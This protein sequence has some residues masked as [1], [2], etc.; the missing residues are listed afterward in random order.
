MIFFSLF[1]NKFKFFIDEL[2]YM[3]FKP[4]LND[5]PFSHEIVL[6][7]NLKYFR[8]EFKK[9]GIRQFWGFDKINKTY[10]LMYTHY[11]KL[12]FNKND[13][14]RIIKKYHTC[15]NCIFGKTKRQ[16]SYMPSW[17]VIALGAGLILCIAGLLKEFFMK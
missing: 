13:M 3:T 5:L 1:Y 10:K 7:P 11:P 6:N 16:L 17:G 14:K 4:K 12:F 2:L 8:T 9:K 15:P